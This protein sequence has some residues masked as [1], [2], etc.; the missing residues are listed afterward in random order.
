MQPDWKGIDSDTIG[1]ARDVAGKDY[2]VLMADMFGAGYGDKPKTPEQLRAGMLAVHNDRDFTVACGGKAY[3]TLM[4]E[5]NKLGLVDRC[6]EGGDRL[7]RRRRLRARTGPRRRRFQG[8][9]GVP[10]HQS[11]SG[12]RRARRATSR[13]GCWRSTAAPIR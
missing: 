12:R 10:R 1:Q 11:Q 6:Q 4:A 9:G 3:E 8:G 13:A 7:L 2:V 5:A